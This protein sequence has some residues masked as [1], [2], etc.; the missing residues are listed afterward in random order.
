AFS[1]FQEAIKNNPRLKV[2]TLRQKEYLAD[3]S[4]ML[5]SFIEKIGV[6]IAAL[7]A[8]GALFGA[9]NTMYNAVAA[10][11][12]EIATLRALG[13]GASPVI[14]SVMIES[15]SLALVGGAIGAVAA[16]IA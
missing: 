3:Q 11:T 9:L 6:F 14:A 4:S 5:T 16:Y 13:F 10:R 7:M 15:L 1:Q 8:L 2:K 12:R